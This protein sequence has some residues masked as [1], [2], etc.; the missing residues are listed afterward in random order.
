MLQHAA[1]MHVEDG[2]GRISAA[3]LI[4]IIENMDAE[5]LRRQFEAGKVPHSELHKV[6]GDT[7][8]FLSAVDSGNI[9]KVEVFRQ[10]GANVD[11]PVMKNGEIIYPIYQSI[12]N[13][14]T[15]MAKYLIEHTDNLNRVDELGNTYLMHAS[16]LV[17]T[18][19]IAT[20]LIN[21]GAD[22][23]IKNRDGS[24]ALAVA[25]KSMNIDIIKLLLLKSHYTDEE[26]DSLINLVPNGADNI[27]N[28]LKNRVRS[29]GKSKIH[30][31]KTY[32]TSTRRNLK[33]S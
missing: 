22:V 29:G 8:P 21:R 30:K 13:H 33:R 27:I 32:R 17:E 31:T 9:E 16:A 1:P 6:V 11:S 23:Y 15:D 26:I 19:E 14:D 12:M 18:A 10:A 28:L 7:T 5:I 2:P 4:W 25:V 3:R 20:T 24:M